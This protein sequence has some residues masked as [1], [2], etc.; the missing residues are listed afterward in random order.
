MK[1][2]RLE[3]QVAALEKPPGADFVLGRA[4]VRVED[5]LELP[6]FTAAKLAPVAE[7]RGD[8]WAMTLLT[9]REAFDR[10]GPFEPGMHIGQDGDW[11]MRAFEVAR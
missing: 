8:Y 4:E 3:H 9:R 1:L 10:V 7:G 2:Y 11:L 6:A 5:G